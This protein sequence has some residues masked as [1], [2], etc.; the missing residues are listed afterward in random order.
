MADDLT[1]KVRE[2][3]RPHGRQGKATLTGRTLLKAVTLVLVLRMPHFEEN[4][5]HFLSAV[6]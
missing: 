4:H 2:I 3:R 1:R 5:T 6:S